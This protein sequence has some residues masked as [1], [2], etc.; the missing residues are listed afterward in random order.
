MGSWGYKLYE[1]DTA[2]DVRD[3]FLQY[4]DE[5]DFDCNKATN[6]ILAEYREDLKDANEADLIWITLADTQWS[7]GIL[8]DFVKENALKFIDSQIGL[9][10]KNVSNSSSKKIEYLTQIKTK[11]LSDQPPAKKNKKRKS[12]ICE[13]KK[14]DTFAYKLTSDYALQKGM[15]NRYLIFHKVA[16][17][18]GYPDE[19]FPV[20]WVK[21]T[22]GDQIPTCKEDIDALD[23]V[24]IS[25]VDEWHPMDV[26]MG[27]TKKSRVELQKEIAQKSKIFSERDDLGYI[28]NYRIVLSFT[29]K[30]NIPKE[31]IYLGNFE[32]LPPKI[33]Y[34]AEKSQ[35]ILWKFAEK[36]IIDRYV[37]FNLRESP[38]YNDR[39]YSGI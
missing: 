14:G 27:M 26:Y 9:I 28:P 11:L 12:F 29:S 3:S 31:M 32:L 2:C 4:L 25:T 19:I 24:Q 35:Q 34:T 8:L 39:I 6:K 33:N 17:D 37:A 15:F 22:E 38:L 18:I 30:R 36:I 21:Y 23:F 13:W 5:N 10:D 20:V 7:K 16:E 1:N